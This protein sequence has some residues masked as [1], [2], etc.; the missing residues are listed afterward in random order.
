MQEKINRPF[1]LW[2]S[3]FSPRSLAVQ[4]RLDALRFD[5]AGER[6][7]WLEGRGGHGVLVA[8]RIGGD[9]RRDLTSDL[10]VRGEVGYGGGE[11][12]VHDS[13]LYFAVHRSGRL[14]RQS[15]DGGSAAAITPP[16]GAA[17]AA[18]VSP[19]GEYV[20]Y[21][22]HD[23]ANTDR[24][25]IVDS[26]GESWPRIVASG[27]DFYMQPRWRPDGRQIAWIEW[28]HPN[29]PWDGTTL[30]VADRI[31]SSDQLP[32]FGPPRK[33]AG[34]DDIAVFQSEYSPDGATLFYISDETGWGRIAA[35]ELASGK[36]RWLTPPDI[37]YGTPAWVQDCRTYAVAA[38][39]QT[40]FAAANRHGVQSIERIDVKSGKI[41]P[42]A[43]LADYTEIAQIVASPVGRR[44]AII[45][46]SPTIPPRVVYFDGERN[47]ATVIA[48]ATGETVGADQLASCEAIR[49]KSAGGDEAHGL[50]YTPASDRF[51]ASGKPPLIAMIHGGPTSQVRA[52]W[53]PEAQFFATRGYAVLF[54]NYRGGTGHGRDYMLKLRGNWGVCDVEDA[55]SA[56]ERLAEQGRID[57]ARA[58]I[59]GGSAGGFTVLQTMVERPDVFAAGVC[60]YGVSDQFHL[61]AQT[62]KFESR[63]TDTLIG[64]LPEAAAIYRERSPAQRAERICRPLAL[65]QGEIDQVVPQEQSDRVAAA[66]QRS[67]I[68]HEYHIYQGEGH[69]WRRPETIEHYFRT[70]DDFLRKHVIFA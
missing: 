39:G 32:C 29:M 4:L 57:P 64:P 1:G 38:D 3:P 7:V 28:N 54:V 14:Y 43:A 40:L 36:S 33:I 35:H 56:V 37:E 60:L 16:F 20:L 12:D 5:G 13:S 25:A 66:L 10:S 62:H 63:Y 55:T 34:G 45:G 58:I 2:D 44:L 19:D 30:M 48:R 52:G 68:P 9:G 70:V 59:M 8:K 50:F 49:W 22:H 6:I 26:S 67:G 42:V 11:F 46:S 23:G 31:D 69:G 24:L 65:Y 53:R 27:G 47:E 51:S 61:A 41:E 17:A 21:V 18:T 15:I